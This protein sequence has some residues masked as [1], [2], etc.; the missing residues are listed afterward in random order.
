[1]TN[2]AKTNAS[3]APNRR[4]STD[5]KRLVA[6]AVG[7]ATLGLSAQFALAADVIVEEDP[8]P[9]APVVE[10]VVSNPWYIAARIGAAFSEDASFGTSGTSVSTDFDA[11]PEISG[12]IGYK[13]DTG[14]PLSYR[15]EAELGYMILDVDSHA[16]AGVGNFSGGD[17]SGETNTFYGLANA[18]AQYDLGYTSPYVTAGLGYAQTEFDGF[19][20][21]GTG[22]VLDDTGTGLIWQVGVG[23][24]FTLTDRIDLDIGYRY[25]GIEDVGVSA[26]DG[27]SSDVDLRSHKVLLGVRAAF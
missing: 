3:T 8:I 2:V 20:T 27:T 7:A 6:W 19:S 26:V 17:A 13:F 25:S 14:S 11:G 9:P 21:S 22:E 10:E 18:Y 1:M 5:K 23:T 16:V 4:F 24:S 12:A 15:I